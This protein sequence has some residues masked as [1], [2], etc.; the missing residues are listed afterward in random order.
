[1]NSVI[2]QNA[3]SFFIKYYSWNIGIQNNSFFCKAQIYLELFCIGDNTDNLNENVGV[4]CLG[5]V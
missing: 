1:M 5:K 2:L 3:R 4:M